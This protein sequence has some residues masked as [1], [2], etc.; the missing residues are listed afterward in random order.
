M[1]DG[2]VESRELGHFAAAFRIVEHPK[3][4]NTAD[5]R[6]AEFAL[7]GAAH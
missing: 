5:R 1:A 7:S 6:H 3:I 4:A 2:D